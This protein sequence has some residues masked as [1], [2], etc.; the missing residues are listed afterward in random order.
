MTDSKAC[1]GLAYALKIIINSIYGLTAAS[2][3]NR[4]RDPRNVDNIVAKRGALFMCTLKHKV[5]DKGYKVV[6]IKTDS[7]KIADPDEEILKFVDDF[8][9]EYGY[10]FEI[11]EEFDRLLLVNDAV[12]V[13]KTKEGKWTATGAEFK[14]PY[15]FKSL[16]SKEPIIFEDLCETKQVQT[17]IYLDFN[18]GKEDKHVYHFVGRVG[19]FVPVKP[20]SGGGLLLRKVN[21][22]DEI[23]VEVE[24]DEESKMSAVTGSKGYRWKEAEVI[25]N[26]DYMS[27]LDQTYYNTLLTDAKNHVSE[28]CDYDLFV[29]EDTFIANNVVYSSKKL[30]DDLPFDT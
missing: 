11:E 15:V 19:S 18:E 14:H 16:F 2:F 25:K 9:K 28:F 5:Q 6:H 3:P 1:K 12:Y 22:D 29:S 7:I 30:N 26:F 10:T 8:G 23:P 27:Q 24:V 13:G 17:E 20:G 4:F 21:A